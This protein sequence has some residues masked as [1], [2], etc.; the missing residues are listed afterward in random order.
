MKITIF[1]GELYTDISAEKE[2]LAVA[3][4]IHDEPFQLNAEVC[5]KCRGEFVAEVGRESA[6]LNKVTSDLIHEPDSCQVTDLVQDI[7]DLHVSMQ[8]LDVFT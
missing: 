4:N 5:S 8:A 1:R 2:P 3:S 6:A 7:G